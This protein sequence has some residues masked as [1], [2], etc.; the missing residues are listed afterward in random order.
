VTLGGAW[1]EILARVLSGRSDRS[2]RFAHLVGLLTRLGFDE[3]IRGDHHIFT[4]AGVD[5]IINVQPTHGGL[6][7][8]YQVRQVRSIVVKYKL[9]GEDET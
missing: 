6:A 5:E 8:P 4:R 3:R 7:K 9:D 2:L 1:D